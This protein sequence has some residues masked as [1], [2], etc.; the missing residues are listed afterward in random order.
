MTY[1]SSQQRRRRNAR[2]GWALTAATV[3]ATGGGI[4]WGLQPPAPTQAPQL[5]NTIGRMPQES[6]DAW[7][8]AGVARAMVLPVHGALSWDQLQIDGW[9]DKH[10]GECPIGYQGLIALDWENENLRV[11]KAGP[12]VYQDGPPPPGWPDGFPP[13]KVLVAGHHAHQAVVEQM[14]GLLT[15]VRA[16][17]PLAQVGYYGLPLREYWDQGDRWRSA[18]AAAGPIFAASDVILPSCYELYPG[19]EA[20]DLE[21]YGAIVT[22]ALEH[23]R[24]LGRT[25]PVW[26]FAWHRFHPSSTAPHSLVPPLELKALLCG[27]LQAEVDGV[28]PAGIVAWGAD[29]YYHDAA[30]AQ[31]DEGN[32]RRP[33]GRWDAVREVYRVELAGGTIEEYLPVLYGRVLETYLDALECAT[34]G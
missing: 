23:G 20:R 7:A 6:L 22:L 10:R 3:A 34:D 15:Y 8:D 29:R 16:R 26:L 17:R 12:P 4:W 28:R 30:Y 21:R 32:W 14:V 1:R 24:Q 27:L 25:R 19:H 31:D 11:L 13:P 18:M 9:L 2:V 33:G 5:V